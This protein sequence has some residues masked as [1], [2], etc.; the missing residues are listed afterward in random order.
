MKRPLPASPRE[1]RRKSYRKI[2]NNR[3]NRKIRIIRKLGKFR[4]LGK[5]RKYYSIF[6]IHYS[7]A[8]RRRL[9]LR[10]AP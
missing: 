4:I 7:I 1:G 5:F 9:R 10:F 3:N 2:Q 6:N 8:K